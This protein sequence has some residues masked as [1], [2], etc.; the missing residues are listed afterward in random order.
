MEL[1][2]FKVEMV[3]TYKKNEMQGAEK[4]KRKIM[5]N[6]ERT[7]PKRENTHMDLKEAFQVH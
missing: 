5:V 3:F 4:K 1:E 7:T 6:P 2:F